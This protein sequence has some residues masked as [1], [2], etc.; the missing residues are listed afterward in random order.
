MPSF[1][2]SVRP[3]ANDSATIGSSIGA[4]ARSDT[5]SESKPARFEPVD[6]LGESGAAVGRGRRS[7]TEPDSDLHGSPSFTLRKPS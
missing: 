6:E 4:V 3:A 5:H 2:F 7:G 1:S